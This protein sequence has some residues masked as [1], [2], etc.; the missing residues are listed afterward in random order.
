MLFDTG[1]DLALITSEDCQ[2]DE[3]PDLLHYSCK[4][5]STC[6]V[7]GSLVNETHNNDGGS[8]SDSA[9]VGGDDGKAGR[10][11][12]LLPH[13]RANTGHSEA[14][15]QVGHATPP[16]SDVQRFHVTP[17]S[18]ESSSSKR[19]PSE[20]E[21]DPRPDK[22]DN[23]FDKRYS[24]SSA[25]GLST[26]ADVE[27]GVHGIGP[28]KSSIPVAVK[29]HLDKDNRPEYYN[30]SFVDG[31]WGAGIFVQDRFQINSGVTF[32]SQGP[33]WSKDSDQGDSHERDGDRSTENDC[34]TSVSSS[35]SVS[36]P[37]GHVALV[38]FLNVIQDKMELVRGYGG[39][40]AGLLGLS[41]AS[42][43]GHK[44]FLQALIEQGAL[45]KPIMSMHLEDYGGSF[46]LGGIDPQAY[47][48]NMI[49]SPVTDP[50]QILSGGFQTME[51][52][53]HT[54]H[55]FTHLRTAGASH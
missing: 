34:E 2:G 32:S 30:Q 16:S 31:S 21:V 22:I 37:D 40:I 13:N 44:T 49:Y 9:T 43:T 36:P 55:L 24:S 51:L 29:V 8:N 46:L 33:F 14:F 28:I 54:T 5:S 45:A 26:F 35:S 10:S 11:I 50:G 41:R 4:A 17:S 38:T 23:H 42:P 12:S 19:N 27:S 18:S 48:G 52:S 47:V 1:S 20:H 39:Q 25:P 3:C 15:L 53:S 7:L 6:R